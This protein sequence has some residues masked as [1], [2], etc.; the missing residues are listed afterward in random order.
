MSSDDKVFPQLCHMCE[1]P[2]GAGS[3]VFLPF[4]TQTTASG[5]PFIDAPPVIVCSRCKP[6][7]KGWSLKPAV[8]AEEMVS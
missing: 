6:Y 7:V 1:K 5:K 2:Q 3:P 4:K 8:V